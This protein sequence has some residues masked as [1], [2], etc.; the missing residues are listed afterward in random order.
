MIYALR[1]IIF[2]IRM[3]FDK[4][5]RQ[6]FLTDEVYN[7]VNI[8]LKELP[9]EILESKKIYE[10]SPSDIRRLDYYLSLHSYDLLRALLH[11]DLKDN[12]LLI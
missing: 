7:R 12:T 2:G 9:I 5:K 6:L 1:G 10:D 8:F 4:K 11:K 3:I